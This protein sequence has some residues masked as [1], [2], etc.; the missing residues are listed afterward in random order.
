MCAGI[1]VL[2]LTAGCATGGGEE[3]LPPPGPDCVRA[4]DERFV[5]C[6]QACA[7]NDHLC[8]TACRTKLDTCKEGCLS[9]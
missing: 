6:S 7:M 5:K 3:D 8:P 1:A 9:P 4:C 2:L